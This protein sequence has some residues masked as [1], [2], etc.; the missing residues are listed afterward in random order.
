VRAA[1]KDAGWFT[2]VGVSDDILTWDVS[3]RPQPT[4]YV[5]Y[6]HV[7]V[8]EPGLFIRASGDPSVPAAVGFLATY[9]PARR[10]AQADPL[11]ATRN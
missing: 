4:A 8:G 9:V 5:P 3:N 7:P 1:D 10:A 2:M 11:I 6:A